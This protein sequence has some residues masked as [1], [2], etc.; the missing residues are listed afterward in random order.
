MQLEQQFQSLFPVNSENEPE[1]D[2]GVPPLK[3]ETTNYEQFEGQVQARALAGPT[4]EPQTLVSL[5]LEVLG[6]SSRDLKVF[7]VVLE[8]ALS[9]AFGLQDHEILALLGATARVLGPYWAT[10]HPDMKKKSGERSRLLLTQGLL[11]HWEG[12]VQK[13]NWQQ[14]AETLTV[15]AENLGQIAEALQALGDPW[16][17]PGRGFAALK[18]QLEQELTQ[19]AESAPEPVVRAVPSASTAKPR[20]IKTRLLNLVADMTGPENTLEEPLLFFLRRK[21]AFLPFEGDVLVKDGR[22]ELTDIP[23]ERVQEI[24]IAAQHPTPANLAALEQTLQA[25]PL[26]LTGHRFAALMA[27]KLGGASQASAIRS[28]TLYEISRF[29]EDLRSL[30]FAHGLAF[31]DR[32]TRDWLEEENIELDDVTLEEGESEISENIDPL[33]RLNI[34]ISNENSVGTNHRRDLEHQHKIAVALSDLNHSTLAQSLSRAAQHSLCAQ[35]LSEWEE[36]LLEEL[37]RLNP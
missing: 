24:R 9:A 27:A 3:N 1:L 26:W 4:Y 17:E 18:K 21:A 2:A 11:N 10:S 23:D 6:E 5:G 37:K 16:E 7:S 12:Y 19:P 25:R 31:C 35:G 15:F 20:E 22:T 13:Q 34:Q 14:K 29:S 32:E 28:A 33:T 8:T 30:S 36:D